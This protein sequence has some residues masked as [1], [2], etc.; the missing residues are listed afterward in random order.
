MDIKNCISIVS[1]EDVID[2]RSY[3]H[4]FSNCEIKDGKHSGLTVFEPMTS[5]ILH[6]DFLYPDKAMSE[7]SFIHSCKCCSFYITVS[8][9]QH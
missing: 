6:H 3:A 8:I 5:G 9:N 4:N 1:Y 7:L 2:H